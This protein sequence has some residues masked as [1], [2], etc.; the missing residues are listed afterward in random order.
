MVKFLD[1]RQT[2]SRGV[3]LALYLENASNHRAAVFAEFAVSAS[4]VLLFAPPYS[5][6]YQPIEQM[7]NIA[8]RRWR[9]FCMLHLN[10]QD[11]VGLHSLNEE[12]LH[13]VSSVCL[14]NTVEACR[15]RMKNSLKELSEVV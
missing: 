5:P 13:E 11:Y 6:K 7:W 12:G 9:R 1:L 14:A 2:G 10:F 3:K 8:K 15:A 4:M